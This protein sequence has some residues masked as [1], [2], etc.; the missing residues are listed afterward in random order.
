VL[1]YIWGYVVDYEWDNE[2]R[3]ANLAKHGIDFRDAVDLF[4]G[5]PLFTYRSSRHGEERY[6]SVGRISERFVAAVWV[7]RDEKL[8]IISMR[9]ARDAE[10]RAYRALFG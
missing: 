7:P 9:S 5:R 4:D 3:D 1:G 2:K 8:R 10:E 6:V